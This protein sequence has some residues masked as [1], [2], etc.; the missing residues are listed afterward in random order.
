MAL[1]R[2]DFRQ[3]NSAPSASPYFLNLVRGQGA[4]SLDEFEVER[5][6]RDPL[7][8]KERRT[9]MNEG[10]WAS[11]RWQ[12]KEGKVDEFIERW[13]DWLGRTGQTAPGFRSAR[14]L[15]AEDDPLRFTSVSDWDDDASLK[16]WKVSPGF[17]EGIE[18]VKELCDEFL[19]G[20]YDVAA[21][22]TAPATDRS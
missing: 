4:L 8:T 19:G 16:A 18:S 13:S 1:S 6:D 12:V 5:D 3:R 10:K 15:R 11:G 9:A 20:D 2:A 17:Q 14:L 7:G 21:V 22:F